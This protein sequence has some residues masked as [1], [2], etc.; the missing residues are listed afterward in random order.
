MWWKMMKRNYQFAGIEISVRLPEGIDYT[1]EYRLGNF[2]VKTVESPQIY[3][4]E[5]VKA[6]D[7]PVGVCIAEYPDYRVYEHGEKRI[8]Y[9]GSVQNTLEGAYIRVTS[10]GKEH[11][12]QLQEEKFPDKIGAKTILNSLEAEHL[13]AQNN[14]FI[15]HCSYIERNGKAILFT[16]PSETGKST[17]ADLWNQLRGAKIINGDR[18]AIRIVDGQIYAEGIPFAGSSQYC[19][20][21]SLPIDAIV[22]L[23]QA[24]QTT[25]RKTEGYQAFMKIWEGV[26]VNSWDKKDVEQVSQVVS[27]VVQEIPIFHL[28]CTPDESAVIALE[29]ALNKKR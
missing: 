5:L 3:T 16:A 6:L 28:T 4:I 22:Y 11:F 26:S 8:R 23:G 1:D 12:V 14:S 7:G 20:N 17:Q 2:A 24:L 18:A 21:R 13:L 9:V 19:E 29:E 15:L 10:I 27:E 25:I